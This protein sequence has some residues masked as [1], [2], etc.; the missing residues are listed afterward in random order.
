MLLPLCIASC[1]LLLIPEIPAPKARGR[2]TGPSRIAA[3]AY[4]SSTAREEAG[5]GAGSGLDVARDWG[6]PTEG[7]CWYA[8]SQGSAEPCS[9]TSQ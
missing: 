5:R 1:F 6:L 8:G 9:K 2:L 7:S 3:V 4:M